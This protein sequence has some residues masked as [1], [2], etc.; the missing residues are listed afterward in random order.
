[1]RILNRTAQSLWK[2]PR[3]SAIPVPDPNDHLT[4][5]AV[6]AGHGLEAPMQFH[7]KP[8]SVA[9]E[10]IAVGLVRAPP[11]GSSTKTSAGEVYSGG[12]C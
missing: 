3:G 12:G 9:R 10:P 5:A 7:S 2:L 11:E 1:M 8:V 6:R 4:S